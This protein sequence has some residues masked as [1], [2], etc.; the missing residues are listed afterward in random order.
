MYVCVC[1]WRRE[2]G[3]DDFAVETPR[4]NVL[5]KSFACGHCKRRFARLRNLQK[6]SLVHGVD[7]AAAE[8]LTAGGGSFRRIGDQPYVCA[9]CGRR[10]ARLGNMQK[11]FLMHWQQE[12][13]IDED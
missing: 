11:H 2:N 10:F 3:L 12:E 6:H 9:E 1:R 13:V 8:G 4:G 7:A 5:D